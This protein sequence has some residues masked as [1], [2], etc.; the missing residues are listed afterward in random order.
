MLLF[1]CALLLTL[2]WIVGVQLDISSLK[3]IVGVQL[4]ISSLK[5]I[6]GVQLV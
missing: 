5:G 2:Q 6:V 3:G 1:I 4:D